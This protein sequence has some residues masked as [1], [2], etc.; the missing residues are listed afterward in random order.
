MYVYASQQ[1]AKLRTN[2]RGVD[3]RLRQEVTT[4]KAASC[5]TENSCRTREAQAYHQQHATLPAVV[6]MTRRRYILAHARDTVYERFTVTACARKIVKSGNTQIF[7][8]PCVG[9]SKVPPR[10]LYRIKCVLAEILYGCQK[11]NALRVKNS[12]AEACKHL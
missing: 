6:L 10:T 2:D 5:S 12:C 11:Q 9:G 1:H 7:V 4:R 8:S 3:K